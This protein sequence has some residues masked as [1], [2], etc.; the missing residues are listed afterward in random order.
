MRA[1]SNLRRENLR[2]R[3]LRIPMSGAE[4]QLA[5]TGGLSS[6]VYYLLEN[7][8]LLENDAY[9][10]ISKEDFLAIEYCGPKALAE[11]L[12]FRVCSKGF[13]DFVLHKEAAQ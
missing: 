7:N 2:K 13:R 12:E 6:R 4:R 5:E 11:L 9:L 3:L 8:G 1:A 10:T